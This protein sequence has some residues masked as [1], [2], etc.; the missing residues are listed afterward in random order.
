MNK[1]ALHFMM[2]HGAISRTHLIFK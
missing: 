1:T 2:F